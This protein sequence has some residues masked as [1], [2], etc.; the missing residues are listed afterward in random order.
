MNS[1]C[2]NIREAMK[3]WEEG[4]RYR[5]ENYDFL[6]E[7]EYRFHTMGIAM[8]SRL[9]AMRITGLN[10]EKAYIMGLLHDYGKKY[11]ESLNNHFHGLVGYL[12]LKELGWDAP[13]RICLTHTFPD[14]EF[15]LENYPSYPIEDLKRVK[16]ILA[17]IEY[18]D[19]DRVVQYSDMFLEG[20]KITTLEE[21]IAHI[22]QRYHLSDAD[23][24]CL[25]TDAM[26]LKKYFDAKCGEDT[27]IILGIRK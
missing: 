27:Y 18:D 21:R 10:P 20:L 15:A 26:C 14:K 23:E 24:Q 7:D 19:Y 11:D 13:A 6:R 25:L 4:I 16:K 2:P 1:N 5:R 17:D 9:L 8:F 12:E 3:I 22:K